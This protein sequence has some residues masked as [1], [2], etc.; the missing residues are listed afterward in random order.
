MRAGPAT[1]PIP[2]RSSRACAEG[3]ST[4]RGFR[5]GR[6]TAL[7]WV[8]LTKSPT[9]EQSVEAARR[10]QHDEELTWM[11]FFWAR[12]RYPKEELANC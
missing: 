2:R 3:D 6:L 7:A 4:G 11:F 5:I 10:I 12:L 1:P 8:P 9:G